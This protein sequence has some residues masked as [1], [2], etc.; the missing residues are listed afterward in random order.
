MQRRLSSAGS[1]LAEKCSEFI[2]HFESLEDP[3]S[4]EDAVWAFLPPDEPMRSVAIDTLS[5]MMQADISKCGTEAEVVGVLVESATLRVVARENVSGRRSQSS[6]SAGAGRISMDDTL[7]MIKLVIVGDSGVG[8]TCLMLRFVK[9]EFA[10]S[11]RAT[12]GMDFCTRQLAVDVMQASEGSVVQRLTV[13][14]WDTAGQEQF[15][16]LTATYYRKA[17]GVLIVYD[18][19]N[20]KSFESLP[21]WMKQV[22]DNAEGIVK[23]VVAAK[24]GEG[25]GEGGADAVSAEEGR[26][27]AEEYGCLFAQTSSKLGEGVVPAFKAISAKVL[28][29]QEEKEE[30]R[31]GFWLNSPPP[32]AKAKKGCC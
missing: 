21:R 13:Q 27:L 31:Q 9:D 20:R 4:I 7:D 15:H 5:K 19:Q 2:S 17:G 1:R 28:A 25:G 24:S 10:S 6:V 22:E 8:K 30:E 14:V 18:A 11:T 3:A 12:I 29:D 32:Q 16:S 26:A 23:M